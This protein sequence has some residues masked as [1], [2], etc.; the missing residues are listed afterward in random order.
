MFLH[1][2]LGAV[3]ILTG[4]FAGVLT[5][6]I[7]GIRRG[8]RE[9]RLTGQPGSRSEALAQRVL[10]GSRGCDPRNNVGQGQ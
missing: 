5:L 8:D 3:A 9:Q 10:T 6:L 2:V 4:A 1:F 7:L